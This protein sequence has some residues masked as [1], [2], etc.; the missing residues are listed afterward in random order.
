MYNQRTVMADIYATRRLRLRQ[1]I[2]ERFEGNRT[3]LVRAIGFKP[4][5][6][7][8]TDIFAGRGNLGD[9]TADRIEQALGLPKG[10]MDRKVPPGAVPK[11]PYKPRRGS[12]PKVHVQTVDDLLAAGYTQKEIARRLEV[13]ES[14]ISRAVNKER[15]S[16]HP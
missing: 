5:Y 1:L 9:H 8:F 2:E 12:P 14:T 7:R 15:K 13:H 10:W 11:T 16:A 6:T 3:A 4:T